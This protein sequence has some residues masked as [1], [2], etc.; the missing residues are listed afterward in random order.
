MQT[1]PSHS[2]ARVSYKKN[3]PYYEE[4]SRFK[5]WQELRS[6]KLSGSALPRGSLEEIRNG[7]PAC[8]HKHSHLN[9]YL[10]PG[11]FDPFKSRSGFRNFKGG[12][13]GK[14]GRIEARPKGRFD[15]LRYFWLL[16]LLPTTF[17]WPI[18][19]PVFCEHIKRHNFLIGRRER[20]AFSMR[21]WSV[22]RG[23][24]LISLLGGGGVLW[25]FLA[26]I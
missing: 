26:M 13:E 21:R 7:F 19:Y 11:G 20:R 9:D 2:L 4:G 25:R 15:M 14:G 5:D 24:K 22:C 17:P 16:P 10:F 18:T 8:E 23:F 1:K 12:R 3:A 6:D